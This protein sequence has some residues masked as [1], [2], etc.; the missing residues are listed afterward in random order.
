[1]RLRHEMT[2]LIIADYLAQRSLN[3]AHVRICGLLWKARNGYR[4]KRGPAKDVTVLLS[5]LVVST[6]AWSA[7][8]HASCPS[9]LQEL[10]SCVSC[11]LSAAEETIRST[12]IRD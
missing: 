3:L 11:G 10:N 7:I 2:L 9:G 1:M 5:A 6:R 12:T 8:L 4:K